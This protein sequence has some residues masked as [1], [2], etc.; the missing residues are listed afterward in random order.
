[1]HERALE[2]VSTS[3]YENYLK[4]VGTT[5]NP[6]NQP[7]NQPRIIFCKVTFYFL[8]YFQNVDLMAN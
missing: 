6:T 4:I 7:A 8:G 2:V 1:M 3:R 5:L